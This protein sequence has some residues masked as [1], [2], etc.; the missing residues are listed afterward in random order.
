MISACCFHNRSLNL[1]LFLLV[2]I[3]LE[4]R[5][6]NRLP[7]VDVAILSDYDTTKAERWTVGLIKFCLRDIVMISEISSRQ[8]ML[9]I[10]DFGYSWRKLS[11]IQRFACR[12]STY[13]EASCSSNERHA[14]IPLKLARIVVHAE[15]T[16]YSPIYSTFERAN[17][18]ASWS[19]ILTIEPVFAIR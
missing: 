9:Y 16:L 17:F 5:K 7:T 1:S 10:H 12:Q 19:K 6:N 3:N 8:C 14:N 11:L 4:D 15:P 2:V 13:C 18:L